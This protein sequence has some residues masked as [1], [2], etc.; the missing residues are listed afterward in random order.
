LGP[1]LGLLGLAEGRQ[2]LGPDAAQAPAQAVQQVEV[3]LLV[4][5]PWLAIAL[6]LGVDGRQ[7]LTQPL[8]AVTRP[9]FDVGQLPELLGPLLPLPVDR[10]PPAQPAQAVLL[11]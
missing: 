3:V 4:G 10:S 1:L 11:D 2:R 9:L 8:A 6:P 5:H 7:P